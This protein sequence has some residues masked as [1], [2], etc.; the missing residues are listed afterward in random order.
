MI[1]VKLICIIVFAYLLTSCQHIANKPLLEN[2][3]EQRPN[4][5]LILA[6]DLGIMDTQGYAQKFL[7]I[8]KDSTYYE[9]PNINKLMDEGVSFSQAYSNQLCSP[10]RASILTGKYAGRLGFTTALPLRNTYYN[11]NLP[12]PE[13]YLA[14]DIL[15]HKDVIK[16]EQALNNGIS[17]AAV[18]A[19][20]SFDKGRDELSIAEALE[21]YH[22]VFIGKWHIGGFGAKGYQPKDHGFEALAW[23]DAGGSS[24]YNW[25]KDWNNKSKKI[26]PNMPQEDWEIGNTGEPTNEAYLTDDL[27]E[28]ALRFLESQ[29]KENSK[30]FFLYFSHF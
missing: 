27:T 14:H 11:Q 5:I 28:K 25:E 20:T 29:S 21:D 12:V 8:H 24:Y 13:G 1:K 19:G 16:I 9:T 4:I 10:T 30:P 17:N 22:S 18:A 6:D 3:K 7:N 26:F 2:K 23:Y 15:E